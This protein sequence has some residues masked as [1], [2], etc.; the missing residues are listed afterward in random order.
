MTSAL[1]ILVLPH[2]VNSPKLPLS[3][4]LRFSSSDLLREFRATD[5]NRAL[6]FLLLLLLLLPA[7]LLLLLLLPTLLLLLLLLLDLLLLLLLLLALPLSL[8]LLLLI[9]TRMNLTPKSASL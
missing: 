5:Q 1:F 2:L 9:A 4:T 6:Q 8:L 3:S 7:L